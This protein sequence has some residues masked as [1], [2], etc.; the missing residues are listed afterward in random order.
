ML[1][2]AVF[3]QT[4]APPAEPTVVTSERLQVDYARNVGTFTGNVLAVDPRITVRADQMVVFF[5]GGTNTVRSLDK[6]V[7][8]GGVVISQGDRK[9]TSE[10]A[11]YTAADGKVVLTGGPSV[12][13]PDGVVT[14]ERITFWRE[15]EKMEVQSASE[16]NRTRLVIHPEQLREKTQSAGEKPASCSEHP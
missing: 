10:H 16:T 14:G 9:A 1:A 8:D 2:G 5:G 11:E 15:Q 13:A 6:I 7:A 12:K 4:N 3:A